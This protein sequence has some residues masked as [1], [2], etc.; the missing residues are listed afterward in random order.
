MPMSCFMDLGGVPVNECTNPPYRLFN[1][2]DESAVRTFSI[3]LRMMWYLEPPAPEVPSAGD[4]NEKPT[5]SEA[6]ASYV[7]TIQDV[8]NL[9]GPL[10]RMSSEERN[11]LQRHGSKDDWETDWRK[12]VAVGWNHVFSDVTQFLYG[13]NCTV[14]HWH[15]TFDLTPE[16]KAEHGPGYVTFA[17]SYPERFV[18]GNKALVL[19]FPTNVVL[20]P[21]FVDSG[22]KVS[23][24]RTEPG[25]AKKRFYTWG[26]DVGCTE[27]LYIRKGV[28][29][30]LTLDEDTGETPSEVKEEETTP[31]GEQKEIHPEIEQKN[32]SGIAAVFVY[33]TMCK[34][35]HSEELACC[36]REFEEI[37]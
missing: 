7:H 18:S 30:A 29:M 21:M 15:C 28:T 6:D 20:L 24:D 36:E 2:E 27:G 4:A 25:D 1:Y 13:V 19:S 35:R 9:L 3:L 14:G 17:V 11:D 23:V 5:K 33:A 16:A 12:A 37:N 8:Y 34:K 31:E 32:R 10:S 26:D 22:I